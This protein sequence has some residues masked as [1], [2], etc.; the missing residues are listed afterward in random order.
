MAAVHTKFVAKGLPHVVKIDDGPR[1]FGTDIQDL[2]ERLQNA[3]SL[4]ERWVTISEAFQKQGIEYLVYM[5]MRPSA[6]HDNS[7]ILSTMPKWWADHYHDQQ[8]ARHDPYFI[9]CHTYAPVLTGREFVDDHKDVLTAKQGKFIRECGETGAVS[10]ISSPV[11]LANSGHFGGWNFLTSLSRQ[12][13]ENYLPSNCERLQLMGF[14]AHQA[15]QDAAD[16]SKKVTVQGI[17]SPRE[18]ECLLWLSRGLRSSEIAD[19]LGIA[20]VTVDMH[21]KNCRTKLGAATREE[22]LVKAVLS[23]EIAP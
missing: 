9:T 7:L 15:L 3:E 19:R 8:Y 5:Y 1:E 23:G 10:G 2:V 12:Q 13:F 21:F 17:L 14:V 16:F 6:P 4:T 18:K 22:A 20:L 11:R